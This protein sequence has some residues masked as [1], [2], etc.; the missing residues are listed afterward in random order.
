MRPI[1]FRRGDVVAIILVAVFAGI[2]GVMALGGG[3]NLMPNLGFGAHW[4]CNYPSEGDPVC[5]K[6]PAS[7]P[8]RHDPS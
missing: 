1:Y 2:L 4:D 7:A 5:V 3:R 6:S 8:Q